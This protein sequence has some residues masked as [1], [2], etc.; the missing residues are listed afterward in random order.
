[1]DRVNAG[2]TFL[3]ETRSFRLIP[4]ESSDGTYQT[5]DTDEVCSSMVA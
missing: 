5:D 3:Q 2:R 1:M 4:E